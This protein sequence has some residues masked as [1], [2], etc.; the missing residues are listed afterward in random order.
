MR[1]RDLLLIIPWVALLS[2]FD[3]VKTTPP[4]FYEGDEAANSSSEI[5]INACCEQ[6]SG[7]NN[8]CRDLFSSEGYMA[9]SPLA[10]CAPAG[11]CVLCEVGVNC[12]CV[13]NRDCS[14]DQ[15]CD[16]PS[17][18]T[19]CSAQFGDDFSGQR[20]SLCVDP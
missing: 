8:F 6:G 17:D 9:I 15:V 1:C 13:S 5:S 7:G 18:A 3:E 12:A 20:C 19:A 10:Q 4:C 16:V 2:C 14:G 11:Y